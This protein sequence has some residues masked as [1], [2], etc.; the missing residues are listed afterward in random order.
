M[1]PVLT[2]WFS[3]VLEAAAGSSKSMQRLGQTPL[4]HP[5]VIVAV[6]KNVV[7]GREAMLGAIHLH[8]IE[9]L[10]IKLVIAHHSPVVRC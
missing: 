8:V 7:A 1:T 6:T 3:S 2:F 9:L 5:H 4:D 10:H